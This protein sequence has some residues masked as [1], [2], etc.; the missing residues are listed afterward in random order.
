[1]QAK[2]LH[3]IDGDR[4]NDGDKEALAI[5][6]DLFTDIKGLLCKPTNFHSV[7]AARQWVPTS[8]APS[9]ETMMHASL[10]RSSFRNLIL[11]LRYGLAVLSSWCESIS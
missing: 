4:K 1:M 9:S 2:N 7:R 8:N 10:A 3:A 11:F 5:V 6:E